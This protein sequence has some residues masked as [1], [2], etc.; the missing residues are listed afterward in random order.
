M[1]IAEIDSNFNVPDN[2]K[3]DDLIWHDVRQAPFSIYGLCD[4]TDPSTPFHRFPFEVGARVG[5][6]V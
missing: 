2:V 6:K 1:N 5:G 3:R 4:P